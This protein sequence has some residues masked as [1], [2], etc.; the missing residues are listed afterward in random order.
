SRY[1]YVPEQERWLVWTGTHWRRD[2]T[3][4]VGY[5]IAKEL[6]SVG[7]E[8]R[9]DESVG[10][11]EDAE[12]LARRLNDSRTRHGVERFAREDQRIVV[13]VA[14]L[15]THDHFL[16]TP[17]GTIDLRTGDKAT[18]R[19]ENLLTAC[20]AVSP[21]GDGDTFHRVLSEITQGDTSLA[22]YLQ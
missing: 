13:S 4:E 17:S 7:H 18:H 14:E 19:P 8:I 15:D 9:R 12:K 11:A 3:R 20:T 1:R 5:A 16:N 10:R 22:A 21:G 6:A 2:T